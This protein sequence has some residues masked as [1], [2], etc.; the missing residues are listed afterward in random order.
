MTPSIAASLPPRFLMPAWRGV[1]NANVSRNTAA[2]CRRHASTK[3]P[4][5]P[6]VLEKPAKFNP[7]SHGSRL[8]RNQGPKHYGGAMSEA[9][10]AVQKRRE[11]PGM[12]PPEGSRTHKFIHNRNLHLFI[13]L[14]TLSILALST[15]ILNFSHTSPYKHLLPRPSEFWSSPIDFI[16]T[17]IRVLQLHEVDR[18]EKVIAQHTAHTDDVA[19]RAYYRKVHGLD[20]SNP[21]ANW[22][23][24]SSE[25][26]DESAAPSRGAEALAAEAIAAAHKQGTR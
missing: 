16:G 7:P 4:S 12:L 24:S 19:K 22:F 5:K 20:K 8:P 13:S 18:N 6:I 1:F 25:D 21:V 3:T 11:Y 15:F 17:W 9:E 10:K 14:G 23:K 26:E 2:V